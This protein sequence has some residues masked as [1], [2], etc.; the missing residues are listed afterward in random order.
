MKGEAGA[1]MI[2]KTIISHISD[3]SILA[4]FDGEGDS[5]SMFTLDSL[6]FNISPS[7]NN[8]FSFGCVF[9]NAQDDQK[10]IDLIISS[11]SSFIF[12]IPFTLLVG[13]VRILKHYMDSKV[14]R[15]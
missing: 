2:I 14:K 12:V 11:L 9:F 8:I 4:I 6:Q 15:K 3:L 13:L 7:S 5:D 1:R 10:K